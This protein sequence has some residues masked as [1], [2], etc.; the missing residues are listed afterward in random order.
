[1]GQNDE[2]KLLNG[3]NRRLL[4]LIFSRTGIVMLLML[5]EIV[6]LAGIFHFFSAYFS[7]FISAQY[8]FSIAMVLYLFNC[9]MESSA[10]ITWLFLL[11]LFPVPSSIMLFF[12]RRDPVHRAVKERIGELIDESRSAA[13]DRSEILKRD[14]VTDS[15]LDNLVEYLNRS[16][17]SPLY[18]N[19]DVR[20]FESGEKK[21]EALLEELTKAEKFIFLEYFIIS[22]GDMWGRILKILADKAKTGVD[23]R[24]MYDG[25][26]E[27]TRLPR[28]YP[29]KLEALG[30]KCKV[31]MPPMPFVTTQYNYRDHRKILVIDGKVAF[32]G[33]INLADEYINSGS[34]LGHW[35]DTAVM[36]KGDAVQSFTLMF[37][38]M[39][40]I[41]E[42]NAV[43][44][45][46]E[47]VYME[48]KH[49][50]YVI[51]YGDCPLDRDHVGENVYMDILF[52][53]KDY[54][55]IMTP[56]LILDNELE[57]ALT[58]AA[59]RGIDV[60]III[61][62]IPDKKIPYSLART[63]FRALLRAGVKLYRYT[64]GFVH[65]KVFVNDNEKAVV[66]S[67]NCDYRSLYH[68]FECATYMYR[69]SCIKDIEEDFMNTLD[70]C[71]EITEESM[72]KDGILYK[73]TGKV[74]KV[75]APL[76]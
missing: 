46:A 72:K 4:Q 73:I 52:K 15:G 55:H 44:T 54:V 47:T 29:K 63:H 14:E 59:L 32:N 43:F 49:N 1:M 25:T 13:G 33:G 66:G 26:C 60:K 23:V 48:E 34:R 56:Y 53:A 74:L 68:N 27:L 2:L 36:L 40:N 37:L 61:P 5:L 67:I 18:G 30:I 7:L 21:F 9:S 51:P 57:N 45:E 62:G 75:F 20:Y 70:K 65:A 19:T 71:S 41:D 31:W 42:E 50:G 64:P 17:V 8:I 39:W 3:K 35:K 22:E 58:Y 16:A 38:Q 12:V 24:V 28:D 6:I 10:K 69:T 76:M 11:M